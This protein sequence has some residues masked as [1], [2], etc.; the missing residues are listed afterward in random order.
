MHRLPGMLGILLL[1]TSAY[2]CSGL[3]RAAASEVAE[4]HPGAA[5][6]RADVPSSS[7]DQRDPDA[8]VTTST[9]EYGPTPSWKLYTVLGPY[10][11]RRSLYSPPTPSTWRCESS[12][13]GGAELLRL[14]NVY[15]SRSLM[16]SGPLRFGLAS[17]TTP[18][19][20]LLTPDRDAAAAAGRPVDL[21]GYDQ[22]SCG[23]WF[24]FLE[25]DWAGGNA[26][27]SSY[28]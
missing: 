17:G 15:P 12:S 2:G 16:A 5:P 3:L 20:S 26:P 18:V 24:L 7:G 6:P 9:Y 13:G 28:R 1:A 4:D 22:D 19:Y 25:A 14:Q 10:T 11:V 23:A 8:A 27:P 21:L